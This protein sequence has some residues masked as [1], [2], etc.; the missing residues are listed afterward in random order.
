[1]DP[2]ARAIGADVFDI[3]I[4]RHSTKI[5]PLDAGPLAAAGDIIGG[6]TGVELRAIAVANIVHNIIA[7]IRI[8]RGRDKSVSDD[9]RT[10]IK[11]AVESVMAVEEKPALGHLLNFLSIRLSRRFMRLV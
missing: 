4:N 2:L 1:M 7:L 9:E 10:M 6:Q 5:N 11:A 3:G 8:N